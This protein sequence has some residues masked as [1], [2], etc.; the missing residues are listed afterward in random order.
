MYQASALFISALTTYSGFT[1]D[2]AKKIY[3]EEYYSKVNYIE[4]EF[5]HYLVFDFHAKAK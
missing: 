3:Y 2:E 5:A 4:D 1:P